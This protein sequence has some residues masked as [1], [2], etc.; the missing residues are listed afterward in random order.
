M[1]KVLIVDDIA[2]NLYLLQTLLTAC[3]YEVFSATNGQEALDSARKT[4]PDLIISDILMPVMDGYTLCRHWKQDPDL[5]LIPFVFY[6]ATYTDANDQQFAQNLGADQFIAKPVEPDSFLAIIGEVIRKHQSKGLSTRSSNLP[7]ETAYLKEYNQALIGKLEDKLAQLHEAN[8]ALLLKDFAIESSISGIA[9][10]DLSGIITYVNDSFAAMW[11]LAKNELTGKPLGTLLGDPLEFEKIDRDLNEKGSWVGEV[12]AQKSNGSSFMVQIVAHTVKE[13]GRK[14]LCRM[15][16]CV[17]I[18]ERK[19]MEAELHR[20]R[21]WE[22]LSLLASGVAHDFNNLLTGLFGNIQLAKNE[23][24]LASPA[25]AYLET[26]VCVFERTKDLTKQLMTF[27]KGNAPSKKLLHVEEVLRECIALS[28]SGSNVCS[29]FSPAE[30]LWPVNADPNQISQVFNNIIINAR[31]AM[32][33]GGSLAISADNRSLKAGQVGQL[34][35]GNFVRVTIR[36]CG[37]GIPDE[38]IDKIFDPFFTTKEKGSGL[39]L[40]TSYSIVK[41]HGGHIGVRSVPGTGST[42]EV[43]LPASCAFMPARHRESEPED[44][45]GAGRVLIMDD[46]PIVLNVAKRMLEVGGFEVVIARNGEEAL[47]VYQQAMAAEMPIDAVILDLTIRGGMGGAKTSLELHKLDPDV[48]V[49]LSTGYAE[50]PLLS[51][52]NEFGSRAV[53]PKPYLLHDLIG[54]VK[55]VITGR[56]KK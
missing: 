30:S 27:A 15:I 52:S 54:T 19:R 44:P 9:M 34:P 25:H 13:H 6:S 26:V 39:G 24:P 10:A 8:A 12:K 46:E 7:T 3:G 33:D 23:L 31:Q 2:E 45:R 51:Q 11:N 18:S 42:F 5:K 56:G 1:P 38:I 47:E 22:S 16:S 37:Q 4:A 43:W 32:A 49:I 40:A 50:N 14:P 53:I 29:E 28:L 36:D 35:A 48:A 20:T 21:N 55:T 17:D 41:R